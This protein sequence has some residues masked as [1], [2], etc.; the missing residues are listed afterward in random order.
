MPGRLRLRCWPVI[1][2]M[3]LMSP[4]I[5]QRNGCRSKGNTAWKKWIAVWLIRVV[6]PLSMVVVSM[7]VGLNQG[8]LLALVWSVLLIPF[9]RRAVAFADIGPGRLAVGPVLR[10][11]LYR[12]WLR[13]L[14]IIQLLKPCA[15]GRELVRGTS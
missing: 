4:R 10:P 6:V 7:Q 15:S 8:L 14:V 11:R 9:E 13:H 1:T 12:A 3:L 5:H 2:T